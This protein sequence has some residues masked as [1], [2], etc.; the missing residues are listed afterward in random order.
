METLLPAAGLRALSL[1]GRNLLYAEDQQELLELNATAALI[2]RSMASAGGVAAAIR[3][4]GALGL[5]A[6]RARALVEDAAREWLLAGYLAPASLGRSLAR[7]RP[8]RAV[9]LD[10]LAVELRLE[11]LPSQPLDAVFE[12]LYGDASRKTARRL[13]IIEHA[14]AV[15]LYVD[16]GLRLACPVDG[17]VA[18]VK[19]VLTELYLDAV[20]TGFL[21]HGA[22]LMKHGRRLLLAGEP[23]AGKTTL[24]LALAAA[25]WAYGGDDIVRIWPDGAAAAA[26]FAATVKA[27]GLPLLR[28]VWPQLP[29]LPAWTRPDGQ[30]ARYFLPPLRMTAPPG[31]LDIVVALSRRAGETAEVVP[32]PGVEALSGIL[33][34]ACARRWRMNGDALATLARSLERAACVRLGYE[35]LAAAVN[36]LEGLARVETQAA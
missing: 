11:G 10:E 28:P 27:G 34:A 29:D 2:W 5:R 20:E 1:G 21:A 19:A 17:W 9:V 15:L 8:D 35:D 23:G 12:R 14:G 24:A 36:A 18:G 31:P 22:L 7:P 26:P 33:G 6:G 13:T 32:L 3:D 16:R 30:Q 25:G 4:L